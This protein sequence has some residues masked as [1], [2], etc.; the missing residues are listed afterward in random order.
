LGKPSRL[1][2]AKPD[3]PAVGYRNRTRT[4]YD[5]DKCPDGLDTD[6]WDC[7]LYFEQVAESNGFTIPGRPIVYTELSHRIHT[8][9]I[10]QVY[11]EWTN[12][13]KDMIDKFFNSSDSGRVDDFCSKTVFEYLANAV[14]Q[15]RE[16]EELLLHGTRV[17]QQDRTTTK[18]RRTDEERARVH[19]VTR[20]YSEEEI[21]DKMRDWRNRNESGPSDS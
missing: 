9:G 5:R 10:P 11:V 12:A 1:R 13:V 4:L 8:T 16:R 17:V 3:E 20:H 14:E 7:T 18:S 21:S 15:E 2:Q 6:I 19:V